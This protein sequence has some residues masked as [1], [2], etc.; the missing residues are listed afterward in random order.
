MAQLSIDLSAIRA[1]YETLKAKVSKGCKVSA[2]VKANAYGLGVG[3]IAPALHDAGCKTFFVATLAEALELRMILGDKPTIAALNGFQ[4]TYAK[5]Y[6]ESAI[7]PILNDISS[8]NAYKHADGLPNAIAHIDTGM[9]RL[10]IKADELTPDIFN[11]LKLHTIMSHFASSEEKDNP[12]NAQQ[13]KAFDQITSQY[14]DIPKSL[15]NSSGIFLGES[16]HYDLA[17]PGMAIYGLNPTPYADNPMQATVKLNAEILQ[18]HTAKKG[19]SAGY[20]GTYSFDEKT[21]VAVVD[22]GYADG[23]FRALSNNANL[24]YEAIACPIIGNVSMDLTIIDLGNIPENQ[25]PQTGHMME[26]IGANQSVD[27]LA[28]SANTIG[29]EILTS[30]G[31]RFERRYI[32]P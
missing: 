5:L 3:A 21:K 20:N 29:Y 1:N 12:S 22:V 2:V 13:A 23:M 15:C 7:T 11:A 18:I 19:E 10:G 25:M 26:I 4:P 14:P 24:Y 16:Y 17:R 6:A 8:L 30:L 28:K 31:N 9:N 27:T 32:N